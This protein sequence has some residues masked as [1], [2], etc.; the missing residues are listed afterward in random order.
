M[1]HDA[2]ALNYIIGA[3]TE[4]GTGSDQDQNSFGIH[5]NHQYALVDAFTLTD[6]S[7]N[8]EHRMF[9]ARNPWGETD[10]TGPWKHD[11]SRWTA[12]YIA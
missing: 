7:G 4:G 11:D 1:I 3:G 12:A 2:S 5:L 10:Y 9:M 6:G 8:V